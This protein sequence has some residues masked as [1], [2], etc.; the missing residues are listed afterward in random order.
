MGGVDMYKT[1][2]AFA[3]MAILL[4][5]GVAGAQSFGQIRF[6]E[7]TIKPGTE[8]EMHT[9]IRNWGDTDVRN[10]RMTMYIPELEIYMPLGRFTV[11]AGTS[12][13]TM[14]HFNLGDD[15]E[16]GDYLIR[17]RTHSKNKWSSAYRH[18]IV[19]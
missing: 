1:P 12:R 6:L 15:V 18:L 10:V 16:P 4:C 5:V 19:I 9:N 17:I 7:D 2:V 8:I 11:R 14:T 13:A 3:L